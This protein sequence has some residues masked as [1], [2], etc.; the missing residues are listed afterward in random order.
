MSMV[1]EVSYPTRLRKEAATVMLNL[2][3]MR[4]SLQGNALTFFAAAL[5]V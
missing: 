2:H 1:S 3:S 4:Q 5:I